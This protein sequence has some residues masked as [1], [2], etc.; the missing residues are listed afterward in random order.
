LA[1]DSGFRP[2]PDNLALLASSDY[3]EE[4]HRQWLENPASLSEEWQLFFAGFDLGISPTGA[5]ASERGANQSKVASLIFAYRNIGHL[6]AYLDPLRDP[7]ETVEALELAT[8][9]L[10]EDNLDDVFD[11]GHLGGP[12]KA[13][14]R[15]ILTVLRDTYCRT[16]GV[17][18]LHLQDR[19]L[20]RWLQGEM[21]PTRNRPELDRDKKLRILGQL[22]DAELF[23]TFTHS[24]Y[25]GQKRFSLEG[26]DS[27]IPALHQFIETAADTGAEEIVI[28]MA[29]RGRLNVLA[30][31]LGKPYSMIFHEFEDNIRPDRY[32]G[33]GDVKYHRGYSSDYQTTSGKTVHLS[34]TANPS[35]LEAVDPVVEGR[36]RAKQRRHDDTELRVKVL[37][38]LI[39]GDAAFAGQ[40]LVAETLNLSQLKG[41]QT[42]G[43]VHI[44]V[45]NQIGFT[46]LPGDARSTRYPTDVA[47]MVEAPIFHVN[48]DDPEAVVHVI[49][50]ALRFRQKF[51]RDVVVDIVCYRRHGHNEGDEPAFTQPLMYQKIQNRPSTRSIYQLQLEGAHDITLDE[52]TELTDGFQGRMLEAF[53]DV[54]ESCPLPGGEVHAFGG[55]WIGLD[56]AYCFEC[57]DT[58][59]KHQA[60]IEIAR[61]LTTV[62][63]G[64]HLNRKVERRLAAQFHAVEGMGAVDWAL[65][66]LLAF[67]SLLT[68]GIP[69]R[70]SGQDSIRGTFSHR[71]AGWFDSKSG[72]IYV[73]LNNIR[74]NQAR[75]CAYNSMLSE[76]AVLGFDYGYSLVEPNMLVI[77][78]AQFG[79]FSNGAQVIIDQFITSAQDKWQRGSGIV[80]LLPH[81]YEGQGPEHSNAYLERYLMACAEDN[82]QVCNLS[83]PA[84][85]FHVLRRQLKTDF[86]RPL[87][88]MAPKSLL[89]HKRAVSPV[90]DLIS[91]QFHEILDDPTPPQRSR[92]L[93]LCSGKVYYDLLA[94]REEQSIDDVAIVRIEQFYPFNDELF[95][96]VISAYREA[97]EVFWVQ[98][99]TSNRG[100]WN[101][102]M[103]RLREVFPECD[104]KYVG[105][106]PSASPATGSA[107]VHREE[108]QAIVRRALTT[109]SRKKV[110]T[111]GP[112]S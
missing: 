47:K 58:G 26:A 25:Q 21:E 106:G 110:Q 45:N 107:G 2:S 86:R 7:P 6:L 56:K 15:E 4:L 8:F 104:V 24:R 88:I 96:R 41:Y 55:N 36:V 78:E 69:V 28:G 29:H 108:Q 53:K 16:I 102:M 11:T 111:V 67:G 32:G 103:P 48:G 3:V 57:S 17:E 35:H 92:R 91:G 99:E 34:L 18:Y 33:D 87:V 64:F 63:G 42:G 72:E 50:L 10:S 112:V 76:A 37:P 61:T 49:D 71:H 46:T 31:I 79:D 94:A 40:G 19:D 1:S 43:T 89:R 38:L 65:A 109:K 85:Y 100:G 84:Q 70:L 59:V 80:L 23:E 20:R 97:P 93:V 13:T 5:V 51:G 77:W 12:G 52:S 83:T 81:G 82:I 22:I 101:Y 39:H 90:E 74:P 54:K 75:F 66:E 68:D 14:L 60:L 73:P 9:D 98:E 62:P 95:D 44:I 30:N 105:R 27:L